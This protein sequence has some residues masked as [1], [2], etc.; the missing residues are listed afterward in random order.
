MAK[1]SPTGWVILAIFILAIAS[2]VS[3]PV[4]LLALAF[5]SGAPLFTIMLGA[6]VLG[7]Y[8]GVINLPFGKEFDGNIAMIQHVGLGDQVETMSTIPLFIYAGY[9]LAESGTADRLVRFANALLGW[10]PGGLAIVTIGTCALFTVF[11]GASGVTIIALGGVLMPALVRQGYPEKFSMGLIAGTGSV[12]LLF[13]PALP[14]FIYGTVYGLSSSKE[15]QAIWDTRRFLFAG[16]VPG[17]VLVAML[18]AV[19]VTVAIK[20]RLPRQ[21]FVGAELGKSFLLA[22]PELLIPFGVIIGLVVFGFGLPEIAALTVVYTVALELGVSRLI[23][24]WGKPLAPRVLWTTSREA[25]AM[26]GAI[27]IIIFASTALTDFMVNAEVPRKIVAWTQA[28]VES[29]IVFLLAINV[30]LLVVGTVMDIFSAIVVV[31]P[32]IAPIAEKYGV[33]PYHLGVIFLLNLEVGYLH[34]PVGL[35]L[36]ITSVK[37]QRPITEVMWATIPFLLTM[38]VALVTITYVPVLTE[39]SAS[40]SPYDPARSGRAQDLATMIHIAVEE[41][42]VVREVA[43]VDAAGNPL[44][45]AAGKPVVKRID[46]CNAI[47]DEIARGGCQQ[48]FFDVKA[49]R[50]KPPA[51][52]ATCA[53]KAIAHWVVNSL[54]ASDDPSVQIIVV[55]EVPLVTAG[56]PVK[57][58]AGAPIV[59]QLA[60]CAGSTDNDTCRDLFLKVSGC[61]IDPPGNG[62][63][64]CIKDK[65]SDW[66]ETNQSEL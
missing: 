51:E 2:F 35:N 33:D 5:V 60:G 30:I 65:V 50:G 63:D 53:H 21:K 7:A 27:F 12:G 47:K 22:V 13:P 41:R 10:V 20:K 58:K 49:C 66:V 61:K 40:M 24:S 37:F 16:I 18:S 56:A 64:E 17:M 54:N 55:T 23:P 45:D 44:H 39:I 34:P 25:I 14:L 36:F 15:M 11:T 48:V 43:L 42:S 6:T 31:L 19:A 52:E 32:L 59:K 4:A 29:R 57:D 28:H 26:V 1:R 8:S 9:L 38:I 3:V 62:I 46:D